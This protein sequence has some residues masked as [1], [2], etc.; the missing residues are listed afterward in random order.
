MGVG[1]C[2][3]CKEY[4][5]PVKMSVNEFDLSQSSTFKNF[6]NPF[7]PYN[8]NSNILSTENYIVN[9]NEEEEE[10]K[11]NE[12]FNRL[13]NKILEQERQNR[14]NIKNNE[15][16]DVNH[17][18]NNYINNN[19][20]INSISN[21]NNMSFQREKEINTKIN[22]TLENM[23]NLG[24]ITKKEIHEEKLKNPEKFIDTSE[25]LK[26]EKTDTLFCGK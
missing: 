24:I 15:D 20:I 10:E 1:H 12:E 17:E 13:K 18:I 9:I 6:K 5:N 14:K 22:N 4:Y 23:C 8:M 11:K 2:T 26:L 21:E 7:F 19:D 25:A 3:G 16:E